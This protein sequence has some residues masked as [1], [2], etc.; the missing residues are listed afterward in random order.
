M[1]ILL[2]TPRE[3]LE[4]QERAFRRVAN[5]SFRRA[6]RFFAH[7]CIRY[8]EAA[9]QMGVRADLAACEIARKLADLDD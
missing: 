9:H 7:G 4:A 1:S 3:R 6:E 2:P 5:V 8:G